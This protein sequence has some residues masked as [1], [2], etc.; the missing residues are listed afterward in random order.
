MRQEEDKNEKG[1]DDDDE[2]N[3]SSAGTIASVLTADGIHDYPGFLCVCMVILIGDMSRGV[4]FPSMWPLIESLGG[5]EVMLGY[6]VAAFSLG[7]VLVNPIF[8]SWSHQ[9]GYSKTFLCSCSLLLLGTLLYA[10]VE[11]VGR[12]EFLIVAQTVLGI[13]S[14]TL[15]VTRAFVADVTARRNR[16]TYM[17]FITAVQYGGFTVT[18][19]VGALFNRLLGSQGGFQRGWMRFNMYTA[20]AYFMACIVATTIGILLVFFQDRQRLNLVNSDDAKKSQKRQAIDALANSTLPWP[21]QHLS[22]YDGCV[23]GCM[24]LNV[25]T[26]GSIA[27]FETLGIAIAQD[28]FDMRASSAGATI[29]ACG[30]L[31]VFVLLNMDKLEQRFSDVHII[32]FGMLVMAIGIASL[33]TIRTDDEN[34]SW[35]YTTAMFMIYAIGYPVG[36]TAVIGLFSK[37]KCGVGCV[38]CEELL[39]ILMLASLHQSHTCIHHSCLLHQPTVVGRRPQGTLLGWFAS[40]GSLARMFFPVMSGYIARYSTVQTLFGIL[41][42]VLLVSTGFILRARQTLTQLSA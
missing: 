36:H 11:N 13:G 41:T 21:L 14:G 15:G 40:A 8:G 34:P 9:I 2:S 26:K 37:S 7:R 1:N 29:A 5:T 33:S 35:S 19:V 42:A 27:T 31:G 24:L 4:M 38:E 23:L 10:Q 3:Q 32:S 12:V 18:P 17:A 22:V 39:F 30:L 28:Y 20:P 16:T 6:S 25:S